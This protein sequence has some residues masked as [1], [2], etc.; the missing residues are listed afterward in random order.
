MSLDELRCEAWQ[1]KPGALRAP[2]PDTATLASEIWPSLVQ[3]PRTLYVPLANSTDLNVE[4]VPATRTVV[5]HSYVGESLLASRFSRGG[6]GAM[7]AMPTFTLILV[8]TEG[9]R[10]GDVAVVRDDRYEHL[11][12]DDSYETTL[13]TV[14]IP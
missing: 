11:L 14:T 8:R 1:T 5:L 7:R 10:P 3:Q 12:G 9:V 13:G 2:C 4:Y 6:F